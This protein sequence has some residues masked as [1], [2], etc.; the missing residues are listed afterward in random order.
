[1]DTQG[2]EPAEGAEQAGQ[3]KEALED[4]LARVLGLL[5]EHGETEKVIVFGTLAQGKVHEW[6]DIDLLVVE[7][8][9]LPFFKRLRKIRGM[10]KP[11]VGMDILVYTPE[12][13]DA[14]CLGRP[15]FREEILEKGRVVYERSR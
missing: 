5:K 9:G 2:R 1:M 11:R 8:T 15:F 4:E 10:L 7:R 12:E 3:R 6:S 14:L 13:F